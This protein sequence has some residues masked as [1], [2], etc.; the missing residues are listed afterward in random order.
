LK[1]LIN[2]EMELKQE[3]DKEESNA[4]SLVADDISQTL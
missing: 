2:G 4:L 3:R 1:A